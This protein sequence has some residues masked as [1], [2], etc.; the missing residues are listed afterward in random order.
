MRDRIAELAKQNGRSMNA[1]IVARLDA[2]LS[3]GA[4][5]SALITAIARLNMDLAR[6]EFEHQKSRLFATALAHSLQE[7]SQAIT[8]GLG[9][10]DPEV[11]RLSEKYAKQALPYLEQEQELESNL[12]LKMEQFVQATVQLQL[13]SPRPSPAPEANANADTPNPPQIRRGIPKP[14]RKKPGQ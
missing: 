2:S 9:E 4:D 10:H 7:A 11:L 14:S 8:S 5:Q 1:E 3:G 12:T 6:A 13:A